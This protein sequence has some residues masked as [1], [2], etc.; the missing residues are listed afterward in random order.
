[1]P[2]DAWIAIR[3]SDLFQGDGGERLSQAFLLLTGDASPLE[4]AL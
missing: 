3:V 2:A 1:M 4:V